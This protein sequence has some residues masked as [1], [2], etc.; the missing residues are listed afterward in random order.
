[1]TQVPLLQIFGC[2]WHS[3]TSMQLSRTGDTAYPV[4]HKHW[5]LPS[6]LLHSP[7]WH[8][9][10]SSIHSSMSTRKKHR[11]VIA[12]LKEA[13]NKEHPGSLM[14]PEGHGVWV[15]QNVKIYLQRIFMVICNY[16]NL[17][18]WHRR[19]REYKKYNVLPSPPPKK[20]NWG[21][22]WASCRMKKKNQSKKFTE[23]DEVWTTL[24]TTF[25]SNL[26]RS[27]KKSHFLTNTII[28]IHSQSIPFGT[29]TFVTAR[30]VDTPCISSTG[31]WYS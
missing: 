22:R 1:M 15:P 11:K 5:K 31:I 23:G 9:P 13:V 8:I 19:N 18:L 7:F 17:E 3:S 28:H 6:R 21:S 12:Q 26:I 20:K 2:L 10:S 27:T 16:C 25:Q 30:T 29:L 24:P 4:L 14:P